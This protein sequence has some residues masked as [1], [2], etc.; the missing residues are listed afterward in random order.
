MILVLTSTRVLVPAPVR[1]N[2]SGI[3]AM[4]DG[5]WN[6]KPGKRME[7][8]KP[9]AGT[10]V[11]VSVPWKKVDHMPGLPSLLR[12]CELPCHELPKFAVFMHTLAVKIS[13]ARSHPNYICTKISFN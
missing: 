7:T 8:W 5:M 2:A 13:T 10:R 6:G 11:P 12:S 9:Y 3:N 1:D 4:R